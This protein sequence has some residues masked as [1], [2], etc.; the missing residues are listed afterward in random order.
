MALKHECTCVVKDNLKQGAASFELGLPVAIQRSAACVQPSI[1]SAE[2]VPPLPA[3][4][5]LHATLYPE[6]DVR[7]G[8]SPSLRRSLRQGAVY[9]EFSFASRRSRACL[10]R[11]GYAR[12]AH[13]IN[14]CAW[15]PF[16]VARVLRAR[17]KS[18][19]QETSAWHRK[20]VIQTTTTSFNRM[21]SRGIL[22]STA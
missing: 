2:S 16:W 9:G 21:P 14:F 20:D 1:S 15:R 22:N 10:S 3:M 11:G 18:G 7:T 12:P 19:W 6:L 4:I 17:C 8:A 5:G 13:L